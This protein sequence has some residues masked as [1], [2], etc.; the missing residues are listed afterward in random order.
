MGIFIIYKLYFNKYFYIKAKSK[1]KIFHFCSLQSCANYLTSVSS[2]S[3]SVKLTT[4]AIAKFFA[5]CS[6]FLLLCSNPLHIYNAFY[7][8]ILFQL[9]SVFDC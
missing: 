5:F 8:S 1:E 3:S 7:M 9:F 2:I 4:P 6:V